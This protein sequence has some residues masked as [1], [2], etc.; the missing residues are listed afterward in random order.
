MTRTDHLWTNQ[1]LHE[2]MPPTYVCFRSS[3]AL[4][5]LDVSKECNELGTRVIGVVDTM[6][7]DG[8]WRSDLLLH[9]TCRR[10]IFTSHLQQLV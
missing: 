6:E 9:L 1:L 8:A 7:E 5:G 10:M 4:L 2:E 3:L